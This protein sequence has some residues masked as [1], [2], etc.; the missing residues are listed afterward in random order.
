MKIG[1]VLTC[2]GLTVPS[3]RCCWGQHAPHCPMTWAILI[4]TLCFLPLMTTTSSAGSLTYNV[5]LGLK[6]AF[7]RAISLVLSSPAWPYWR[8][9]G[10]NRLFRP[11][12]PVNLRKQMS[13]V[14]IFHRCSHHCIALDLLGHL[15]MGSFLII[16]VKLYTY[17]YSDVKIYEK[18]N[19]FAI[20]LDLHVRREIRFNDCFLDLRPLVK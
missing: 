12:F 8:K 18:P 17:I 7:K 19:I 5:P 16:V 10:L 2:P 3:T 14:Q 9:F 15:K 6:S 11:L 13:Y 20:I 1:E 4:E